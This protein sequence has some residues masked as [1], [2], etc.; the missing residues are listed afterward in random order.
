MMRILSQHR[1]ASPTVIPALLLM[2]AC[3]VD[4]RQSV[5]VP[6]DRTEAAAA[7]AM[8][9]SFAGIALGMSQSALRSIRPALQRDGFRGDRSGHPRMLFEKVHS[10]FIEQVVYLFDESRPI[11]VSVVFSK[12]APDAAEA[13][14]SA[15]LAQWGLPDQAGE[16]AG[17]RNLREIAVVWRYSDA[18]IVATWPARRQNGTGGSTTVR[19][20]RQD[21][22]VG[23]WARRITPMAERTQKEFLQ[24][25]Q[26]QLNRAPAGVAYQ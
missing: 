22:V 11:L 13:F 24:R 2:L 8:P 6:I 3:G 15:V 4:A 1:P 12:P 16:I 5:R 19:I 18:L 10:A 17:E 21:S 14:Q 23:T 9:E 25:M 26:D 20:G 7:A